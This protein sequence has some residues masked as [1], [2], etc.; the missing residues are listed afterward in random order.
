MKRIIDIILVAA[1][2]LSLEGCVV[3]RYMTDYALRPKYHGQNVDGSFSF[4]DMSYPGTKAWYD[5]LRTAGV[6]RDTVIVGE[7]GFKLH[8]VYAA[9]EGQPEGTAICIHGYT[10]NFTGMLHI[11][12]MYHEDFGWNVLLPDLHYH[13]LSEGEAIQ[14]GWLDRLDV[15]RWIK[16]AHDV[17]GS[18]KMV[19][20]GVSMGAATTMMVSGEPDIPE[21]VKGYIEDCGYSTV[22]D[23]FADVLKASFHLP[24]FPVL[25]SA[26]IVTRNRYGW[27]FKEASALAQVAKCERP[28]LF[29]HGD[30]DDYV[31][32]RF[33]YPLY[34][35][36]TKGYKQIWIAPDTRAHAMSFRNHTKEYMAT[37]RSFLDIL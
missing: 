36:K 37:V 26:N 24:P 17:F 25:Y 14:M 23:Q 15:K 30:D 20:H 11:A 35:A 3:G 29:I 18:D 22:W 9:A 19:L 21:Y 2:C 1:L 31:P 16:T 32:T 8:G 7:R 34:E 28:M 4:V 5:S 12:R 10:S 27:D 33:V 6:F 13:G